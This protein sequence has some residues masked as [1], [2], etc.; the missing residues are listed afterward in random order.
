MATAAATLLKLGTPC[1]A[2]GN[3]FNQTKEPSLVWIL[4]NTRGMC[5]CALIAAILAILA[6]IALASPQE[7]GFSR[8]RYVPDRSRLK[9]YP[10]VKGL[11]GQADLQ[12]DVGRSLRS[13]PLRRSAF[14]ARYGRSKPRKGTPLWLD[15][16]EKVRLDARRIGLASKLDTG[17]Q[18]ERFIHIVRHRMPLTPEAE[19]RY[20]QISHNQVKR[21]GQSRLSQYNEKRVGICR[22]RAF[23]LQTML[24]E[25]GI[26]A[27]VRY[28]V[29]YDNDNNYLDGHAWVEA[30]VKNRRYL[31]DPSTSAPIQLR[32]TVSIDEQMPDGRVR[33]V[34]GAQTSDFLYV[35]TNDLFISS[36]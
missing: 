27:K 21:W 33:R 34:N 35:P 25:I 19:S 13:Y 4:Q 1:R 23:L 15:S 8:R 29:L 12:L 32:K 9:A 30:N 18:L 14:R 16:L 2:T 7:R 20:E 11:D 17:Q 5:R 10:L 24:K 36:P 3:D 28:G 26:A 6:P 31:L 22:E